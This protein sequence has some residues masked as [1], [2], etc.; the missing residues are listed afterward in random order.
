MKTEFLALA[1]H[2]R[3]MFRYF[4]GV[5]FFLSFGRS[6]VR[7]GEEKKYIFLCHKQKLVVHI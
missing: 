3:T 6:G 4:L 2:Q 5:R 1:L 7:N